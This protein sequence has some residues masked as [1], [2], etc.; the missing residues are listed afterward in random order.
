MKLRLI[1]IALIAVFLSMAAA[2]Y[3]ETTAQT[4]PVG[5][6]ESMKGRISRG[7][8][9]ILY[10][11]VEVANNLNE[12]NTKGTAVENCTTKTKT[13]V[14]RGIARIG[15]GVWQL[16]T[17]WYSDPGPSENKPSPLASK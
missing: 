16:L 7:M 4:T 2:A 5:G 17:F 15:N 14:E 11:D 12:T 13:G 10:G 1:T 6:T 9:N 3:A 8:D